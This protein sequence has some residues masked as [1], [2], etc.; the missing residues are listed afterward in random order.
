VRFLEAHW[1]HGLEIGTSTP[2]CSP[3]TCSFLGDKLVGLIDF[4][5]AC[6]DFL[7]YDL[8]DLHQRLVLRGRRLVQRHQGAEDGARLRFAPQDPA[9]RSRRCRSWRAARRCASC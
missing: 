7:A 4:Y 8:A 2:T 6:T 9:A 3:T 1:P 5:F